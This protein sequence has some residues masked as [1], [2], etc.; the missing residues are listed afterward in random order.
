MYSDKFPYIFIL[1]KFTAPKHENKR[2]ID[3]DNKKWILNDLIEDQIKS[4]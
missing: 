3:V 2:N 4:K 1:I